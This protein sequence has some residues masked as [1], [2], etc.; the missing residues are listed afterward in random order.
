MVEHILISRTLKIARTNKQLERVE[1]ER[2]YFDNNL[3]RFCCTTHLSQQFRSLPFSVDY[4]L[5]P[6]RFCGAELSFLSVA[7]PVWKHAFPYCAVAALTRQTTKSVQSTKPHCE[8]QVVASFPDG[9]GVYPQNRLLPLRQLTGTSQFTA[10][11]W[12]SHVRLCT[13]KSSL[14]G[15][16][17][18]CALCCSPPPPSVKG[19]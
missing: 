6:L 10:L 7:D 18:N 9:P 17:Y 2:C 14:P 15:S 16:N 13:L 19:V 3:D 12:S 11:K 5:D 4:L 8:V 1:R